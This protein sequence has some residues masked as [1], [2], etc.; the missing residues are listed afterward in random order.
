M[1]DRP[2]F[3]LIEKKKLGGW[4]LL[5][6]IVETVQSHIAL[7]GLMVHGFHEHIPHYPPD[8]LLQD[9]ATVQ[10]VQRHCRQYCSI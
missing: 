7:W 6:R 1:A 5:R 2:L 8:S 10:G 9:E 3:S 4:M